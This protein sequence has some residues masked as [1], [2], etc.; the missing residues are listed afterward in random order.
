MK[1]SD[2]I[3][4]R[5]PL[6]D[7]RLLVQTPAQGWTDFLRERE[8]AAYERGRQDGKTALTQQLM[9]H[10]G[11]AGELQNGVLQSL[12]R[13]IPQVVRETENALI[14][15]ALDSAQ[16]I[17]A[18]LPITTEMVE[19]VVRET[20]RQVE[21]SAEITVLLHPDDLALLRLHH[22]PVLTGLPESGP[23]RFAGSS[24][25]TRGGC[26]VQTRFGVIDARRETKLEQLRQTLSA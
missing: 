13:A 26:L 19:A 7:V 2:S 18:G 4:F 10:Q 25:V 21:G 24:E 1:W 22:S 3:P 16:K 6:N 23:L 11:E 5:Q 12:T 17:V 20:V 14:Q 15:L 8:Q 9:Q